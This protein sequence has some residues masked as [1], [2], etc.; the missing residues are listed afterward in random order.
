MI[1][2]VP[3]C[4]HIYKDVF[5]EGRNAR[6]TTALDKAGN[7]EGGS[8]RDISQSLEHIPTTVAAFCSL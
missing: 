8:R 1:I 2:H 7:R 5:L 3:T 6:H 4:I